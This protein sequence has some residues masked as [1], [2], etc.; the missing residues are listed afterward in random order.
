M[1]AVTV[2]L[3]CGEPSPDPGG[4]TEGGSTS[5]GTSTG[6]GVDGSSEGS[7]TAP[8]LPDLGP[9]VPHQT[10]SCSAWVACATEL[11]DPELP[12]IE[13]EYGIDGTCWDGDSALA[14]TCD[15]ACKAA[16]EGTIMELEGMGQ[17]VPEACDP[18]RTV[19]WAEIEAILDAG[20][21][22]ACHEPGGEDESLDL[23]DGAYYSLYGVA[24]SQSLL[25][26]VD[27]G[28]HEDSYLWHKVSGSQGSVGGSGGRM[29]KGAPALTQEEID[30]IAD[31]IDGGA[32]PF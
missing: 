22:T 16:I 32:Q 21:V 26:L 9:P 19:S 25:K 5:V 28:S 31:W 11:G 14:A 8:A 7:T 27:A 15:D 1:L 24:S 2:G 30:A 23:S 13:T 4:G 20:C 12:Q 18:P 29:P 10:A 3:A 6:T 17:A